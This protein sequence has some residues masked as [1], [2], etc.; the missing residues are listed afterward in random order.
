MTHSPPIFPGRRRGRR[1]RP[2][3][4][5]RWLRPKPRRS[6]SARAPPAS[7]PRAA[8]SRWKARDAARSGRPGRRPLHHR[9]NDLRHPVRSRRALDLR[10]RTSIRSTK[11]ALGTGLEIY[12]TPPG[13]KMRIG[14][15]NAR[16]GELEDFL[17]SLVRANRAIEDAARGKTDVRWRKR[18][19]RISASGSH[20]VEFLLGPFRLSARM[21]TNCRSMDLAQSNE[22]ESD[23]FCR[24]G[25]GALL[26]KLAEGLHVQ[27]S[28]PVTR[29]STLPRGG[30]DVDTAKGALQARCRDRHGLD[31]CAGGGQAHLRVGSAE[32]AYGCGEPASLGNLRAHGA[33]NSPA[34]RSGCSAT[35]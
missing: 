14:R 25:F 32:A 20:S 26:A 10:A 34:I 6:S 12:P 13:Q 35:I 31:Q 18:C 23:A 8:S 17:S 7:P 29:I 30:F 16:E 27:L 5:R 3:S 22:R 24:Q 21:S 1:R 9:H 4:A 19:R 33:G 11:L 28:S 2:R 15:R